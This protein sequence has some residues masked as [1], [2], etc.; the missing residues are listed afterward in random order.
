MKPSQLDRDGMPGPSLAVV[1]A[2]SPCAGKTTLAAAFE[3]RL[4]EEGRSH[5]PP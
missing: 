1:V 4:H 2:G 5:S 3:R